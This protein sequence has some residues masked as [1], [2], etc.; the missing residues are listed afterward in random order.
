MDN[1]QVNHPSFDSAHGESPHS[2]LRRVKRFRRSRIIVYLIGVYL[3]LAYLLIPL[4]WEAVELRSEAIDDRPQITRTGDGHPGDPIN[5]CVIGTQAELVLAMELAGWFQADKLGVESDFAIGA[6]TITRRTYD[7]AP[8]SNLYLFG[9]AEDIAFE[10]PVKENP[11]HRH[12]V[13]FWRTDQ[14][15][16]GGRT[17]WLGSASFDKRVG[18]SHTT[19]QITHHISADVDAER[20]YLAESLKRTDR[21]SS[22]VLEPAFHDQLQG[23]NG[24]GDPWTTDGAL[25]IATMQ[26]TSTTD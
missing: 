11:R 4:V 22:E 21:L 16:D 26:A 14:R 10:Q 6:D 18:L 24:G 1:Q 5:V 17:E 23:F 13:R 9:R 3:L 7:D 25:W 8:V 19:G 12:H 20:D 15:V 2:S